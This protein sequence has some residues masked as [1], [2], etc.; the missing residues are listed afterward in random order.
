M[1][2][3]KLKRITRTV[4]SYCD[5]PEKIVD[6]TNFLEEA[7]NNAYIEHRVLRKEERKEYGGYLALDNWIIGKY[8]E[9]EGQTILIEIDY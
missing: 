2:M 9:L 1:K 8:P 4:L 3:S 5:I 6:Q 7:H